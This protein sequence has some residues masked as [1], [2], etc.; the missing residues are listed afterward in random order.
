MTGFSFEVEE[1]PPERSVQW[2]CPQ[3]CG[4]A[5]SGTES[6]VR[7][8]AEQHFIIGCS[9]EADSPGESAEPTPE[10]PI[11]NDPPAVIDAPVEA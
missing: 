4:A 8:F 3:A 1:I 11:A 2:F 10:E 6:A 5:A 9:V 7:Y